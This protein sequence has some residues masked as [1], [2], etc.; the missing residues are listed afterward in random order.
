MSVYKNLETVQFQI[1]LDKDIDENRA[2][3]SFYFKNTENDFIGIPLPSFDPKV[4]E[5]FSE[6]NLETL[7]CNIFD[8]YAPEYFLYDQC[9]I[10]VVLTK[11]EMNKLSKIITEEYAK[12][13]KNIISD[14]SNFSFNFY[15][16][17]E[18]GNRLFS[19]AKDSKSLGL[20]FENNA[21]KNEYDFV[22]RTLGFLHYKEDLYVTEDWDLTTDELSEN[23]ENN[24]FNFNY[25]I[26]KTI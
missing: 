3:Y 17:P 7:I 19:K 15:Y 26:Q 6:K 12:K 20:S 9:Y 23:I 16:D 24:K 2:L 21:R 5:T 18:N 14:F 4:K 10:S 11:K 13:V 22:M 25:S 8:E 1:I